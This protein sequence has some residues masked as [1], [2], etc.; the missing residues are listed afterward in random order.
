MAALCLLLAA[1]GYYDYSKGKIPN[2]LLIGMLLV[3]AARSLWHQGAQGGAFLAAAAFLIPMIGITALLYP[4]FKIG[5]VGAGDV[6]LLGICAGYFPW[7]KIFS[8]LLVSMLAA[9]TF[10][11]MKLWQKQNAKDRFRY[12]AEYLLE[13]AKT[14]EW[15]LY[16]QNEQEWR[17]AAGLCMSGPVLISALLYVGGVY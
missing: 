14:G 15:S 16:V 17:K 5:A 11:L 1:A 13:V 8:F 10:S 7:D 3:G 2:F 12:L 9:A 6:K 4:L